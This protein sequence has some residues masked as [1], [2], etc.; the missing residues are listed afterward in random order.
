MFFFLS[1][2]KN[3]DRKKRKEKE[4]RKLSTDPAQGLKL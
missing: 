4:S 1:S 2:G 3:K